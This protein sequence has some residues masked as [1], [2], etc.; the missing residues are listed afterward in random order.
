MALPFALRR[1]GL[2]RV[3]LP[4]VTGRP[5]LLANAEAPALECLER[6]ALT[7][8]EQAGQGAARLRTLERYVA[9]VDAALASVA[10]PA[11]LRRLVDIAL[12]SWTVWAAQLARLTGVHVSTAVRTLDHAAALGLVAPV[13]RHLRSRGDATPYAVPPWLSHAGLIS[14]RRKPPA[15]TLSA[16]A[17]GLAGQGAV[18][19]F[20][21]AMAALDAL[22]GN[23]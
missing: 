10:R 6:W 12:Q 20:E 17:D 8:A 21:A 1:A 22:Q 16:R 4:A 5:R 7:L 2:S 3:L 9:H 23:C 13:P 11:A 14:V 19:D 18:A 15:E